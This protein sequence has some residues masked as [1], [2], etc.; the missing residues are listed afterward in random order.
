M[1][2][3]GIH[4]FANS[5]FSGSL[6]LISIIAVEQYCEIVVMLY[7]RKVAQTLKLGKAA[8]AMDLSSLSSP[9]S[10]DACL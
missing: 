9:D 8:S 4:T 3:Q 1:Y 2:N 6:F 7:E 5:F 10:D